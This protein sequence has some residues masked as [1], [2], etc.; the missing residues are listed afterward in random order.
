MNIQNSA[1]EQAKLK[2]KKKKIL[3]KE[4]T[5]QLVAYFINHISFKKISYRFKETIST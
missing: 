1:S 5:I 2:K 3:V 4:M